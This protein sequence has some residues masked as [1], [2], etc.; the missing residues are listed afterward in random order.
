[1]LVVVVEGYSHHK[2]YTVLSGQVDNKANDASIQEADWQGTED[3]C[4]RVCQYAHKE[5]KKWKERR[6][7]CQKF[8][9]RAKLQQ[10]GR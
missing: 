6:V 9:N 1:M 4:I 2:S 5:R 8:K 10:S 3:K 7:F